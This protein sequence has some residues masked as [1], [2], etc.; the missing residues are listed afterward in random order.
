MI[1]ALLAAA[2]WAGEDAEVY[3]LAQPAALVAL[4]SQSSPFLEPAT[5]TDFAAAASRVVDTDLTPRPG[6]AFE[7]SASA[8]QLT[9]RVDYSRYRSTWA[10]RALGRTALSVATAAGD[11]GD[12]R[13]AVGLRSALLHQADPLLDQHYA[14]AIAQARELCAARAATADADFD[15]I[16]C[17]K[18]EFERIFADAPAPPWNSSGL[19]LAGAWVS[20]FE[21]GAFT[22]LGPDRATAWLSGAL[23]VQSWGQ[24]GLAL[25]YTHDFTAQSHALAP[26][27]RLRGAMPGARLALEAGYVLTLA[28]EAPADHGLGLS[29]GGEVRLS[30]GSWVYADIG[31]QIDPNTQIITLVQT[32]DLRW[33]RASEPTFREDDAGP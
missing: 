3:L 19:I 4:D 15:G 13:A 8:M 12:V 1:G 29:L 6:G 11:A 14:D 33:G 31:V 27:V 10:L 16:A 28:P 32:A 18:T 22:G 9:R 26:T 30:Q 17:K 23:G 20:R 7:L 5:P 24:A 25:G 21:G 2:V